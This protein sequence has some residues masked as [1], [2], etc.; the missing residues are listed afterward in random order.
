MIRGSDVYAWFKMQCLFLRGFLACLN[1]SV[2]TISNNNNNNNNNNDNNNN[3]KLQLL[4]KL[5]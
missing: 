4:M 3:N 5:P 2:L 1:F